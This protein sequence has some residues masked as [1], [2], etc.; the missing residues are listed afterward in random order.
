V[1]HPEIELMLKAHERLAG[2]YDLDRWH[3]RDDTP[4]LDICLGA[5]LVQH[6]AWTNVEKAIVNLKSAGIEGAEDLL[7]L[8]EEDLAILVRPAG[9]PLTKARR[10]QT[11]AR[12]VLAHGSFDG[13]FDR[14]APELR[15]LLLATHGIGPET[16][17]VIML[18]AAR[19]PAIVHDA[20]TARLLGRLGIGPERD[21][22]SVWREWLDARLPGDAAF[23]RRHHAAIVV[24]C[25]ETCRVRP[26][27]EACPL[28]SICAFGKATETDAS[29]AADSAG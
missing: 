22:Y 3:W 11:F 29:V 7:G 9:T 25:K 20:Y 8:S 15:S 17:D 12:L 18:Y 23:R 26:R 28:R 10:L 1:A 24:H 14:P 2:H 6:T 5:V 27:C 16:A 4:V 19:R 13:L 21:G